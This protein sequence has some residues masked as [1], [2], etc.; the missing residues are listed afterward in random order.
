MKT[1]AS[2]VSAMRLSPPDL[3]LRHP[4]TPYQFWVF[5]LNRGFGILQFWVSAFDEATKL[6]SLESSKIVGD[7]TYTCLKDVQFEGLIIG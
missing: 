6:C 3:M 5:T 7:Y 2:D 4:G 1:A